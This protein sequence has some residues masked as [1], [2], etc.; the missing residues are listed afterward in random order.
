MGFM[1]FDSLLSPK[2]NMHKYSNISLVGYSLFLKTRE[3]F[4]DDTMRSIQYKELISI[5]SKI[6]QCFQCQFQDT[7][8]LNQ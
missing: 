2:T 6:K 1:F 7:I 3:E 8:Q 5:E 4:N